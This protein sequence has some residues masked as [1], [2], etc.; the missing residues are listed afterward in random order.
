MTLDDAI[1][2]AMEVAQNSE[3]NDCK[4]E[5]YALALWLEQLRDFRESY[6]PEK[7]WESIDRSTEELVAHNIAK[8]GCI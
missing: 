4:V 3:S 8:R 5:H 2:H 6:E 7:D 1:N